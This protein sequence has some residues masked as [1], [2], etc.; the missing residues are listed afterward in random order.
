MLRGIISLQGFV[1]HTAPI[2]K[3]FFFLFW[4]YGT[5][6]VKR[7]LSQNIVSKRQQNNTMVLTLLIPSQ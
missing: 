7:Q 2:S 5:V 1:F 6:C 3:L 4:Y